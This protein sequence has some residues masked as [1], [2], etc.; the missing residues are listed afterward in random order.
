MMPA[1]KTF[2]PDAPKQ[3]AGNQMIAVMFESWPS[4]DKIETYLNMGQALA[5]H[6]EGFDGFVSIER[7]RSITDPSKLLALSFWR[8]EAAVHAWRNHPVHRQVQTDSRKTVFD[9]YRLRVGSIIRDYGMNER[10]QAPD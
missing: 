1:R 10:Q 3:K 2:H 6:L 8:D 9:N 7:F 5:A 4:N